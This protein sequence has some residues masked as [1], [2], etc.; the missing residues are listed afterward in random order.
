MGKNKLME[1]P[2]EFLKKY[3]WILLI[4]LICFGLF[5]WFQLRPAQIRKQCIY[6]I[7]GHCIRDMGYSDCEDQYRA[8]LLRNGIAK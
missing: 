8:C 5:Y 6:T 4:V 1:K 3:W 7:G 2:K